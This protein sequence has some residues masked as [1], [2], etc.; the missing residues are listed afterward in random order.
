M[1]NTTVASAN[2]MT[3][4]LKEVNH[5]Y[6]RKGRYGPFIGTGDNAI[7]QVKQGLKKVS[8]PLVAN[9]GSGEGSKGST[10]LTGN[11]KVL[12][13]YA[14]ELTP[15]YYRE[16]VLIDNEENE[17]SEFE[18]KKEAKPAL[19][20]WAMELKRD[21]I[22]QALGGVEAGGTYYN[23]GDASAANLD[24]WNT[25]N[26]D[27]I[28]YGNATS[29]LSAGDHTASLATI[30]T[31]NDKCTAAHLR[32]LKQLAEEANPIV[33]PYTIEGDDEYYVYFVGSRGFAS[34]QQDSDILAA[35]KDARA[36]GV[37]NPIF[38]GGD[39]IYDGI[40]I[41][42]VADLKKFIDGDSTGSVFDGVWGANATS[43]DSLATGGASSSRVEMGLFCGTQA[44]G[45]G[46]GKMPSITRRAEDDYGHQNGV[47]IALKHDIKKMFYNNKQHGVVTSFY[48]AA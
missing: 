43:G 10:Q 1:A 3:K 12:N 46:L 39:L 9:L 29:N 25:N 24:T 2:V 30:D 26:T 37:D 33:R 11:E 48:S 19:Q 28:L 23:Y 16:G 44:V 21:H 45:F 5:N 47:G 4:F 18:L 36:R 6:I 41:K 31:T 17:K 40:I 13:N 15:T 27:R 14:F 35:N 34:L 20:R 32:L 7:F 42:K 38:T 22:S 8:I